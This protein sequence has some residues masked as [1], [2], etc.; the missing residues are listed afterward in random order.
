[1]LKYRRFWLAGGWLL[2]ALVVY[3][4]LVPHPPEPF[5]FPNADKLEHAFAYA[6]LSVWFCQIYLSGRS[7]VMAVMLLVGMGIGLEYVQGW[8][9]YRHF[10]VWDMVANG[11]GVLLG[12]LMTRTAFGR[13]FI[14][15]EVALRQIL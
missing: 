12:Y 15:I 8:T 4:S 6:S 1:V 11:I 10:D 9:E 7:R 2:V 13:L 14:L 5:S 3:L